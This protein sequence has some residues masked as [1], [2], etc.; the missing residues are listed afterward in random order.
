MISRTG[1]TR[2]RTDA[3][4]VAM[5]SLKLLLLA[6]FILLATI[7]QFEEKRSRAVMESVASVF[8]GEVRAVVGRPQPDA[9]LGQQ[10]KQAN[11]AKRIENLFEQTLPVVEVSK[12]Q[13]GAVLRLEAPASSL[14][15]AGRSDLRPQRGVLL[16][17]L[18]AALTDPEDGP[19]RYQIQMLHA[20]RAD[21]GVDAAPLPVNRTGTVAR[22]LV[23]LGVARTRVST[24][25]WPTAGD[26]G[27][28]AFEIVLPEDALKT[29]AVAPAP[30]APTGGAG[31]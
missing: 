10:N 23:E 2:S 13:R 17:R 14:F 25:L 16:R 6:F 4:I 15:A 11:L 3:N 30:A 27:R 28:I 20:V 7:S 19:G 5:L 8:E 12:A 31:R 29:N 9:G 18:A 21:A 24:G 26:P 1:K 22:R